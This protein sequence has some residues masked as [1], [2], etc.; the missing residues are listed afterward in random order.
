VIVVNLIEKIVKMNACK[1]CRFVGLNTNINNCSCALKPLDPVHECAI[2]THFKTQLNL[3]DPQDEE[4]F[5]SVAIFNV[6][7]NSTEANPAKPVNQ[8]RAARDLCARAKKG[9]RIPF[10]KLM[11]IKSSLACWATYPDFIILSEAASN[12]KTAFEVF[13][14]M[15]DCVYEKVTDSGNDNIFLC[16]R[17]DA[18]MVCPNKPKECYPLKKDGFIPRCRAVTLQRIYTNAS[19]QNVTLVGVHLA[20]KKKKNDTEP[21]NDDKK[22]QIVV[23]LRSLINTI[24]NHGVV[25]IGGDFNVKIHESCFPVTD[26]ILLPSDLSTAADGCIDNIVVTKRNKCQDNMEVTVTRRHVINVLDHPILDHNPVLGVFNIK[27][28][29]CTRPDSAHINE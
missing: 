1:C 17:R 19:V 24:K 25:I 10:C 14:P 8:F 15:Y 20:V 2:D 6:G 7:M 12:L 28:G 5:L 18:W 29:I 16:W 26:K 23:E 22:K 4:C 27:N 11:I 3:R 21:L 13:L 9:K